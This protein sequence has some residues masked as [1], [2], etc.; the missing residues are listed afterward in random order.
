MHVSCRYDPN[1]GS[2]PLERESYV[3]K[4]VLG[5][6]SERVETPL[7]SAVFFVGDDQRIVEENA[8]RFCLTYVMFLRALLCIYMSRCNKGSIP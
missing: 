1:H 7:R 5:G 2:V 8:F 3:E 6:F 4:S